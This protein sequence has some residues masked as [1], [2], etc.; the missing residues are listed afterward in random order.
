[1]GH[2]FQNRFLSKKVETESYLKTVCCYIRQ[3]PYK[4]K[5]TEVENYPWSSYREYIKDGEKLIDE[6]ILLSMFGVNKQEARENFI[7]FQKRG[8][9]KEDI[10]E[11]IEYEM[12]Q[13]LNDGQTKR[14][15]EEIFA[16]K[17]IQ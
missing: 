16:L 1:M 10:K 9:D 12:I 8:K 13:R 6:T 5:I 7:V 3:N 17:N 15:I 2:V 14:Y 11:F 4:A